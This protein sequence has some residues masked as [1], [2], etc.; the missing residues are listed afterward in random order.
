MVWICFT[1]LSKGFHTCLKSPEV[2]VK[3]VLISFSLSLCVS[4]RELVLGP[5]NCKAMRYA[6]YCLV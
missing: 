6:L 5:F 3:A 1:V 4:T 2:A